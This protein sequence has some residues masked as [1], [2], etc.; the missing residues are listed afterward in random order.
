MSLNASFYQT[1]VS[2]SKSNILTAEFHFSNNEICHWRYVASY[3]YSLAKCITKP[4]VVT[5][6]FNKLKQGAI[7]IGKGND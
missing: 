7:L 5:R 3:L 4:V 6:L 2:F 1:C